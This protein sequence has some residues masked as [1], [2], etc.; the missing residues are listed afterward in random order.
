MT[1]KR[2]SLLFLSLCPVLWSC[3]RG[4][5][6]AGCCTFLPAIIWKADANC[7]LLPWCRVT[8]E[9]PWVLRGHQQWGHIPVSLLWEKADVNPLTADTHTHTRAH[10]GFCRFRVSTDHVWSYRE[11]SGLI[12]SGGAAAEAPLV[13]MIIAA[14]HPPSPLCKPLKDRRIKAAHKEPLR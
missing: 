14:C 13:Q 2:P 7:S 5:R 8:T 4:K 9:S 1:F 10:R 6:A 12:P 11:E 3:I